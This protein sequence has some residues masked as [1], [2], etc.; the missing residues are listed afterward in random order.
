MNIDEIIER[1]ETLN[2]ELRTALSVMERSDKIRELRKQI[3]ENQRKCPHFSNKY[4]WAIIDDT[5]P[6]CGFIFNKRRDY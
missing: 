5:C 3:I 4:D 2:K 1:R 6:Y